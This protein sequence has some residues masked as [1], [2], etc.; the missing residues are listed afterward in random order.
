MR[1]ALGIATA[2]VASL[3]ASPASASFHFMQIEQAIGGVGGDT[4]QQAVQ[5]RMRAGGQNQMQF[6]RLRAFDAAGANPVLLVD[7]T[8]T[9]PNAAAGSR[10]LITTAAFATGQGV[11][12]DFTMTN[13]IP[14]AYLASGRLTFEDDTGNVVYSLC[15]GSYSGPT[16]GSIDNDNDGTYGPCEAGALPSTT[17][18]ALRFGGAAGAVGTTNAADYALTSGPATFSNNAGASA[19]V[20]TVFVNGFED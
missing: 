13:A 17:A 9:V 10:V 16:T 1:L 5:L 14:T 2:L 7:M 12:A 19:T 15:W 3:A 8:T 20:D 4:T 11:A 18:Q 6:S